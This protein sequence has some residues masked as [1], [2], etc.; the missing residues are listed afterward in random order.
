MDTPRQP[1]SAKCCSQRRVDNHRIPYT[2]PVGQKRS[3]L[4]SIPYTAAVCGEHFFK[5]A[6]TEIIRRARFCPAHHHRS[7][8]A[9][10]DPLPCGKLWGGFRITL[11]KKVL[12]PLWKRDARSSTP[13]KTT[14]LR[15]IFGGLLDGETQKPVE[16]SDG[17]NDLKRT[18]SA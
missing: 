4:E 15:A 9:P 13:K 16:N 3:L 11:W 6:V 10:L 14:I 17:G 7:R 1:S 12:F 8:E 5:I 2:K 18:K